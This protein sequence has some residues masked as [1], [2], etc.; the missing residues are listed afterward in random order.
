[1]AVKLAA[2]DETMYGF[3]AAVS[4]AMLSGIGGAIVIM[5]LMTA[6]ALFY[7]GAMGGKKER[8][9]LRRILGIVVD[10]LIWE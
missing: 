8:L 9:T 1:M 10:M 7:R 4:T 5:I 3:A 6:C 2:E